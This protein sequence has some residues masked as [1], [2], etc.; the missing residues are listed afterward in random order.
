MLILLNHE[1]FSKLKP[2]TQN[3]I[4]ALMGHKRPSVKYADGSNQV[5]L[6]LNLGNA[7]VAPRIEEKTLNYLKTFVLCE[8]RPSLKDLL[9][10]TQ[11]TR[12]SDLKGVHSGL[13]KRLRKLT[14]NPEA[15][16]YSRPPITESKN[17]DDLYFVM[18]EQS[19]ETL[20]TIFNS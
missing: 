5:L 17:R 3:E 19:V 2:S 6:D 13:L 4:I 1:D 16:L 12:I 7:L 14:K 10:G 8:G 15:A 9:K 11:S 18:P 20:K